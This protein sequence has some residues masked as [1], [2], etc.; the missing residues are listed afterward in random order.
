MLATVVALPSEI[1]D[2][3]NLPTP[4]YCVVY[5]AELELID[6]NVENSPAC[7]VKVAAVVPPTKA[8][9]LRL[10]SS[11]VKLADAPKSDPPS[12]N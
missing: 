1:T 2:P 3:C 5:F 9:A 11:Q 10:V 7:D 6:D 4:S 12:L 8:L